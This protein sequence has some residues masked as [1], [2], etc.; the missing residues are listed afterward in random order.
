MSAREHGNGGGL[1]EEIGR[2]RAELAAREREASTRERQ[3]ERY[4]ADLRATFMEERVRAHEVE[5]SYVATVE[6]LTNA[7]E[8]RD[9]YTHRHA[10]RVTAYG[11]E[12]A[13]RVDRR[14]AED[15][16]VK[17]GFL[18]HDVGKVAV[19]DGIL[20]KREP[21][22][23]E[24]RRVL[25]EHPLIGWRILAP[26]EYLARACDVVRYHHE[27]WDGTGYPEGLRGEEIP[28]SARVF[29]VADT[30]DAMTTDRPYRAGVSIAEARAEIRAA[31][32]QQFDPSVVDAFE[33]ISDVQLEAI[34]DALP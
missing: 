6:A 31:A 15:H 14:L 30:L 8:V 33:H 1:R 17:F 5:E 16:Q 20:H 29:S 25:D 26:V 7:V 27:R 18:L 4:A 10:E 28:L 11:L 24:E 23:A 22:T 34:R 12:I 13:L 3:L 32:G 21:L 19:P 2:L 9:A